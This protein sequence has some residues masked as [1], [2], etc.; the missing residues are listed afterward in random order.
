M[1]IRL[2]GAELFHADVQTDGHT[3]KHDEANSRFFFLNFANALTRSVATTARVVTMVRMTITTQL[4][5][6]VAK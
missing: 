1:K 6:T 4:I 2:V 3:E 5:S